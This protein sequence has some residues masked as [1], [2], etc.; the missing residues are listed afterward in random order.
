MTPP[1]NLFLAWLGQAL[2]H[3]LNRRRGEQHAL[4]HRRPLRGVGGLGV[5]QG[6]GCLIAVVPDGVSCGFVSS[7]R[8]IVCYT[9]SRVQIIVFIITSLSW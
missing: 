8:V 5:G 4:H 7:C 6:L 1:A 3:K 9:T 2:L